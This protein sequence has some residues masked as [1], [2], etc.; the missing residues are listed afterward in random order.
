MDQFVLNAEL[1]NCKD[2]YTGLFKAI[3]KF[4]S[5]NQLKCNSEDFFFF[6]VDA[7]LKF[8]LKLNRFKKRNTFSF[9]KSLM[10]NY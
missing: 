10:N 3:R 5:E 2:I 7:L 6:M 1:K 9:N 4:K 8:I